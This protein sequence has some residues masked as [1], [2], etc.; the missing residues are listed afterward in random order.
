MGSLFF[1]VFFLFTQQKIKDNCPAN[2]QY[3][4]FVFLLNMYMSNETI[5][6]YTQALVEIINLNF[7]KKKKKK[8]YSMLTLN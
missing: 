2:T 4:T 8:K 1:F 7:R 3:G 5:Y 6:Y